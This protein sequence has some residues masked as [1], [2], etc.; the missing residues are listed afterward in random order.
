MLLERYP[1]HLFVLFY[2]SAI[3]KSNDLSPHLLIP[4]LRIVL[5]LLKVG[6]IKTPSLLS[7]Q[8]NAG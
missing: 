4:F 7:C 1:V 2:M 6:I 3:V 8:E 5:A